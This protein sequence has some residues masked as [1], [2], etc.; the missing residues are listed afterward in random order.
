[1][2]RLC[3]ILI[4]SALLIQ[5][6][7]PGCYQAWAAGG[8]Q[9]ARPI[10]AVPAAQPSLLL[11]P[12]PNLPVS[13]QIE[14]HLLKL[15]GERAKIYEVPVFQLGASQPQ[16][17]DAGAIQEAQDLSRAIYEISTDLNQS[18]E[19]IQAGLNAAWKE[20]GANNSVFEANLASIQASKEAKTSGVAN[21]ASDPGSETSA[22]KP[23]KTTKAAPDM[24]LKGKIVI[25]KVPEGRRILPEEPEEKKPAASYWRWGGRAYRWVSSALLASLMAF[26]PLPSPA[27]PLEFN[28]ET[29]T[30]S[31]GT[32]LPGFQRPHPNYINHFPM[33]GYRKYQPPLANHGKLDLAPA[34]KENEIPPLGGPLESAARPGLWL[35]K[36][37]NESGNSIQGTALMDGKNLSYANLRFWLP[38]QFITHGKAMALFKIIY[39]PRPG[40]RRQALDAGLVG[41]T[42]GLVF[43][44]LQQQRGAQHYTLYRGSY[45]NR[46]RLGGFSNQLTLKSGYMT[47]ET[48][49]GRW[50]KSWEP[51][52]LFGLANTLAYAVTLKELDLIAELGGETLQRKMYGEYDWDHHKIH[53]GLQAALRLHDN[54]HVIGNY[55]YRYM[56][57]NER[58]YFFADKR[59][60]DQV[61]VGFRYDNQLKGN[62]RLAAEIVTGSHYIS[63][64]EADDR[65]QKVGGSLTVL[66]TILTAMAQNGD[67][68]N[69]Y[70]FAVARN[71]AKNLIGEISYNINE[72][73]DGSYK[74]KLIG[75]GIRVGLFGGG[76]DSR[77]NQRSP[78]DMYGEHY[79]QDRGVSFEQSTRQMDS[80]RKIGETASYLGP[81]PAPFDKWADYPQDAYQARAG[82]AFARVW[83]DAWRLNHNSRFRDQGNEAFIL[84]YFNA[85]GGAHSVLLAKQRNQVILN[86]NGLNH[87][88]AVDPNA[89]LEEQT[90]AAVRQTAPYLGM[91]L[92]NE[93]VAMGLYGSEVKFN[94]VPFF[95]Y[96]FTYLTDPK[97][98][99][100]I[101]DSLGPTGRRPNFETGAG[102]TI[103][104]DGWDEQE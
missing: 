37:D 13:Y 88:I 29:L 49:I 6:P 77:R 42:H 57:F 102:T 46:L 35:G 39:D 26:M 28:R 55:K 64:L 40:M 19:T 17:S 18:P 9:G 54:L 45:V 63:A 2:K 61:W 75:A 21:L 74:E 66:K 99:P 92:G 11:N 36:G 33:P 20:K 53:G 100:I 81:A 43:R 95:G 25:V 31:D 67:W 76:M 96:D 7:G 41:R 65:I 91:P 60:D 69:Q 98:A 47:H 85:A 86:D 59:E 4:S 93:P 24:G 84:N 14:P 5:V 8:A 58:N 15:P 94:W 10:K 22:R 51:Q 30:L 12:V 90:L 103:G 50:S 71:L 87:K 48:K 3:S 23:E 62:D 78:D 101:L 79:Y 16:N 44:V 32:P 89:P 68:Q 80:V 1:M 52:Y 104:L 82:D 70:S 73:R 72:A 83:L 38:D 27:E 56:R 34:G 97:I